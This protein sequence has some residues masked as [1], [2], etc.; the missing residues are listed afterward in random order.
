MTERKGKKLKALYLRRIVQFIVLAGIILI[1][2]YSQNPMQWSPSRIV[3]GHLPPPRVSPVTGDTWSISIGN[4]TF[5][6][7]LALID[8]IVSSKKLYLPLIAAVI[9]PLAITLILGRVFCS[10]ICPMGFI[11]EL[12]QKINNLLKKIGVKVN[13]NIKDYRYIFFSILLITAFFF[14][15]PALSVFD[16]PHILGRE[17][18]F[19][20]THHQISLTGILFIGVFLFVEAFSV[21]RLWCSKLCPSGGGLSLLSAKR[22]LHI[23]MDKTLCIKCSKCDDACPYDLNPMRLSENGQIDWLKCDNCGLCRD[24]CPTSAISYHLGIRKH[25]EKEV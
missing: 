25:N 9:L 5:I 16:P 4:I 13:F 20:F 1:P 22:I 11:F 6:H 10:W 15:I 3:L 7:P 17:F 2:F 14:A 19:I 12:N 23:R 18:M 21:K 8:Y 24:V